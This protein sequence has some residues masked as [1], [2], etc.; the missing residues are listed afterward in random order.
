M[1]VLVAHK[2]SRFEMF[3][4]ER[5]EAALLLVERGDPSVASVMASHERHVRSLAMV[6]DVLERRGV[7]IDVR[8][9]SLVRDAEDYD[10][11]IAVGGDGTVLDLSHRIATTPL[12][13]INSD[14]VKS[15]GYFCAGDADMFDA[16]F[17]RVSEQG[18]APSRLMRYHVAING[19]P[20][21]WPIL[22]DILVAHQNPAAVTSALMQVG[23]GDA[24][25]QRS[26]G[27]WISTA[28]GS[29]AAI[30]SAGGYVMALE[31]R[32]IQY[33]VREPCPPIRGA[34]KHTKG[35]RSMSDRFEI[36]SRMDEGMAYLD[37]P[38]VTLPFKLGDVLTLHDTAPDFRVFGIEH[39]ERA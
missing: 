2:L 8:G 17:Q 19:V 29:T 1:R 28:A 21:A 22:N 26:S 31:S 37:G 13:G 39:K 23:E 38:H 6:V 15:V 7:D 24:E 32:Q 4:E 11:V 10:L 25:A 30:R 3:Q 20:H 14:P 27:I 16:L 33:L 18:W 34:Y 9:R 12:L 5:N 35:I 36:T